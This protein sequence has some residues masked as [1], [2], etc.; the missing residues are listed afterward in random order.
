MSKQQQLKQQQ[1]VNYSNSSLLGLSILDNEGQ[2][3]KSKYS[4]YKCDTSLSLS[5]FTKDM[6][7]SQQVFL[8]KMT[9]HQTS[10]P[11][12]LGPC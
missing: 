1:K 2:N 7:C 10:H 3:T 6:G 11:R 12:T 9:H 8:K 4:N 5:G